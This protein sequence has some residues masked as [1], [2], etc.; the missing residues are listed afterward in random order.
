MRRIL[1]MIAAPVVLATAACG[2][3]GGGGGTSGGSVSSVLSS[4]SKQSNLASELPSSVTAKGSITVASDATYAPN[5]YLDPATGKV[6][7]WE[8]DFGK[9][10]GKVLGVNFNFENATFST[11]IPN[12][13]T[14]YDIGISSFT[15][16]TEREKTVD[17]VTYY[18]AG[19][20]FFTKK[21][22][23]KITAVSQLCGKSVSV[24]TGTTEESD[25]WGYLGKNPDG[26]LIKGDPDNC[27]KAGQPDITVHSFAKQTEA[28]T[29]VLGGRAVAG[30]ADE[31]VAHYQVKLSNGSLEI[32]GS[33]CSVYPYGIAMPK[34]SPLEKALKD[35]IKYLIDQGFYQQILQD[36]SVQS[37]ALKSS[38][39]A[40]NSNDLVGQACVPSY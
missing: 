20:I 10:L 28:N 32:S 3:S 25:A 31:P 18:R 39:V 5:E 12:L 21:G 13:G 30:F 27:Q 4:I 35:A 6:I 26:S 22:A 2:S 34:G 14:R 19:E 17:F 7:G 40:L 1:A 9:A 8:A 11:I 15:P 24:E 16:T 38:E 33:A 29:D 36:W 23:A 37:G